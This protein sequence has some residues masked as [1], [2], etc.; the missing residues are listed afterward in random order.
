M[1][2]ISKIL[3]II[4]VCF[5]AVFILEGFGPDFNFMDSLSHLVLTLAIIGI[6]VLAWKKPHIGGWIF[7]LLGGLYLIGNFN[8]HY[9]SLIIFAGL[10][11][12][13]GILFL[14]KK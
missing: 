4:I 14:V 12:L 13:T 8:S 9:S 6:T 10:P 7:I 1:I 5:F 11:I 2:K 3:S